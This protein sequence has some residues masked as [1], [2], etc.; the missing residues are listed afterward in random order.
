[1]TE[2]ADSIPVVKDTDPEERR[3]EYIISEVNKLLLSGFMIGMGV[4]VR[5]FGFMQQFVELI[6]TS[7][8]VRGLVQRFWF[9]VQ[10]WFWFIPLV[11]FSL[12]YF[13]MKSAGRKSFMRKN[14]F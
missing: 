2:D 14:I 5:V 4:C 3:R 13:Y 8:L 11:F 7:E 1:M 9:N 6:H 10:W 12:M